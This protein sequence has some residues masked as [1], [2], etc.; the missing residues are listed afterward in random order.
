MEQKD[1]IVQKIIE[2]ACVLF[3]KNPQELNE[4]TRF[5]ED[6]GAK[7]GNVSQMTTFLEDTYDIE[8]A[9]MEFR[10]K[11]TIAEAAEYIDELCNG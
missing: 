10:R 9:F 4:Q 1:Q 8:I 5:L 7:S 3:N 11:K 2:R 6:L